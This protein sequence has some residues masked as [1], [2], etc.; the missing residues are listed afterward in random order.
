MVFLVASAAMTPPTPDDPYE[1][2]RRFA[3]GTLLREA[4]ELILRQGSGALIL[5]GSGPK[6]DEVCSGGFYLDRTAFSAQRTAE[7]AKMDG[8]IVIDDDAHLITRANVHF[9]PDPT[10]ETRETGTR[11]R[12]AERLALHTGKDVI[13]ISEEGRR[14]AVVF[15]NQNRY[16][17]QS[18]TSL[19]ASANNSLTSLERLRRRL[20][21]AEERL[22]RAEV[23]DVATGRDVLLV[24][25]RAALVMRMYAEV[26]RILVELGGEAKLIRIQ[27]TDLV[28]GVDELAALV[29]GDYQRR[30]RTSQRSVFDRMAEVPTEDLHDLHRVAAV[31]GFEEVEGAVR[32]RG[33]RALARVPRLPDTV[34]Q[35]LIG[36]FRDFQKLLHAAVAELDQVDGVG[37]ARARQLRSYLDR[38]LQLGTPWEL[39]D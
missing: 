24:L 18:P 26:E 22:T 36:H 12:T 8:G 35:A 28:E 32:P 3:P 17:L 2:L 9:I 21:E 38:V 33:L 10:I 31:L 1:I 11:F 15:R 14:M 13:A 7:L 29:Y 6:V 16:E 37:P 25:I 34:R 23:D 39:P 4:T 5:V 27:A 20:Q 19:L 30:R